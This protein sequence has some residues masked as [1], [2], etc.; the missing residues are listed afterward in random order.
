MQFEVV[1]NK[2]LKKHSKYAIAEL[3]NIGMVYYRVQERSRCWRGSTK[4]KIPAPKILKEQ[5]AS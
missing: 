2:H 1:T 5:K 4:A 3:E